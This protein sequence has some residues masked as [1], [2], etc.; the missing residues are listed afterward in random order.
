MAASFHD[1]CHVNCALTSFLRFLIESDLDFFQVH[2]LRMLM[3]CAVLYESMDEMWKSLWCTLHPT[4]SDIWSKCP[5]SYHP[6]NTST[7]FS[8]KQTDQTDV[9]ET[10]KFWSCKCFHDRSEEFTVVLLNLSWYA[11]WSK[12]K[13]GGLIKI[14]IIL[15]YGD[16]INH[17][18]SYFYWKFNRKMAPKTHHAL[19]H[20]SQ[21]FIISFS[22]A[23]V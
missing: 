22:S 23:T 15:F 20:I 8:Y 19:F 9:Q 5:R 7:T 6:A 18:Y 1:L 17:D 14:L 21:C 11:W 3:K 2:F 13:M 4:E 10:Q 12:L 16:R